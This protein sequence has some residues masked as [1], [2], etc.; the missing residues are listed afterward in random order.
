MACCC[1]WFIHPATEITRKRNGSRIVCVFKT[2]YRETGVKVLELSVFNKMEF[3]DGTGCRDTQTL[4]IQT[5]S[6]P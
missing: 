5:K 3:L 6:F 2:H 4:P 1:C